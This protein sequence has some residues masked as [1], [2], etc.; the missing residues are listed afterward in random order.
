MAILTLHNAESHQLQK[1]DMRVFYIP[2]SPML[3]PAARSPLFQQHLEKCLHLFA[4]QV[5][6]ASHRD[7]A[8]MGQLYHFPKVHTG[9]LFLLGSIDVIDVINRSW[10]FL[11][12]A[13]S[14]SWVWVL[15]IFHTSYGTSRYLV[16]GDRV[17]T[18]N[19]WVS[20]QLGT[21]ILFLRN[22]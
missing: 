5:A 8:S 20:T 7:A 3:A 6:F 15:R 2:A 10:T 12:L 13:T 11:V 9:L 21:A 22:Q 4:F 1:P 14:P 16:K 18:A 17:F 19:G